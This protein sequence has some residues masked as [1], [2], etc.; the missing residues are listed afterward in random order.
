MRPGL[1]TLANKKA[2]VVLHMSSCSPLGRLVTFSL[3]Q[4][5]LPVISS[6]AAA[7]G[8]SQN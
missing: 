7:R 2:V 1:I 6:S 3:A 4:V 8:T 5:P